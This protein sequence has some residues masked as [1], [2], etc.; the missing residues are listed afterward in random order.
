MIG[1]GPEQ[2][3]LV[4]KPVSPRALVHVLQLKFV[5]LVI[6]TLHF[7][8]SDLLGCIVELRQFRCV[9]H[10]HIKP[11][12]FRPCERDPSVGESTA[13]AAKI[14]SRTVDQRISPN[15]RNKDEKHISV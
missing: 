12:L 7:H 15:N 5:S 3:L 1:I 8:K 6:I 10:G 13:T 9:V 11:G 4:F 14:V 2:L